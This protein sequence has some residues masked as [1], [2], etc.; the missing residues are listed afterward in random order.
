MEKIG[1]YKVH[2]MASRLPM[3][4]E[5][6]FEVLKEN[7]RTQGV[8]EPVI[9]LSKK[10][11]RIIDGR[12]RAKACDQL[13]IELQFIYLDDFLND[14]AQM[15]A[16]TTTRLGN[17]EGLL[18]A[19][20][21]DDIETIIK[22]VVLMKNVYRRHLSDFQRFLQLKAVEGYPEPG[23]DRKSEKSKPIKSDLKTLSEL[24]SKLGWSEDKIGMAQWLDKNAP[25]EIKEAL[26]KNELSI[27][28][29]YKDEKA[30]KVKK[31]DWFDQSIEDENERFLIREAIRLK[32]KIEKQIGILYFNEFLK[33]FTKIDHTNY[34]ETWKQV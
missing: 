4:S 7:I 18:K 13:G 24:A 10:D 31:P 23:G 34:K 33:I 3:M 28:T 5:D 15:R 8:M 9:L 17:P 22:E 21:V 26:M 25:E 11:P 29:A 20:Q 12:N 27:T 16:D 32:T 2:E 14:S 6:Q 1:K 19:E 30:K